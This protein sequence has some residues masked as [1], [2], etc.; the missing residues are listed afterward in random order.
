MITGMNI[1]LLHK[2]R[3]VNLAFRSFSLFLF[4]LCFEEGFAQFP[5]GAGHQGTTAMYVDSLAF[6]G[7]ATGCEVTR[8]FVNI[9]DTTV[10]YNGLN[11]A[12]YGTEADALGKADNSV[13]SLGDGGSA[14]LTFESP[15]MNESGPDFAVF[16]NS[17]DGAFLEL[18]FVEVSSDGKNFFRFP[19]V[20]FVQDTIQIA[21]FGSIDPTKI[22]NFAGKYQVLYGTPF[23]LDVMKNIP[24]LDV[25]NI[26]H[27]RIT[28]VVGDIDP[29]FASHD[30]QGTIV[31]D[32]W[33]TP[34]N[35]C[36]F[37]LDAVGVIHSLNESVNNRKEHSGITLF[38][39][40]VRT[41]FTIKIP[42]RRPASFHLLTAMGLLV[43]EM[44]NVSNN[45]TIDLSSLHAGIYLGIFTF[46][47]GS[48][49][50]GTIIK[51]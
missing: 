32:P 34:F 7:W 48:T 33:T 23:D 14:T 31:N 29:Q 13:I 35:T 22:N 16:E 18:G 8:G 41:G 27:V 37:D 46:P 45:A 6:I 39:N 17:L 30:S 43:L 25:G 3:I 21:T 28:D 50:S 44:E 10:T 51:M 40:P 49:E 47:D 26:T 11:R 24:G 4:L 38:P 20:T 9:A 36:G 42:G 5:P 19:S 1:S 12:S 2:K 15:V